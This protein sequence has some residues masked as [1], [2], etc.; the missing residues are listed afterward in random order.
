MTFN[1][2]LGVG[3]RVTDSFGVTSDA[4]TTMRIVVPEV[5]GRYAFYNNS[6]WDGDAAGANAA[7]DAAIAPDKQPLLPGGAATFANYTS[8]SRGINGIMID[9]SDLPAGATPTAADFEFRVGNDNAPTNWPLA[10]AAPAISV[11]RGA[12]VG[13]SDRITLTFPDGTA[14]GK[15][16]GVKVL[17]GGAVALASD[18]VFYFGNAI[19]EV[20]NL[21]APQD[22]KVT[23]L[24][25]SLTRSNLIA[26]PAPAPTITNVYDF[27]RDH[28]VNTMDVSL[29]R[30]Y[31]TTAMNA[32]KLITVPAEAALG[33]ATK[34]MTENGFAKPQAA[35]TGTTTPALALATRTMD[36][37]A[38]TVGLSKAGATFRNAL[39]RVL[40]P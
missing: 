21:A 31:L 1:A 34:L 28:K 8:Y 11:R 27:N 26:L 3:L 9:V 4:A 10:S 15:W 35:A 6:Y 25:V 24:D 33:A 19:G 16:L 7:D 2:D 18:E 36:A 13:G 37:L 14:A 40:T 32:L 30:S 17:A 39:G 20:G 5:V 38:A 29:M 12:G 23:T 22:A